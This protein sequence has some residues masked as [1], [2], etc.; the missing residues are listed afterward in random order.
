[1]L[2]SLCH[3]SSIASYCMVYI[4]IDCYFLVVF[5]FYLFCCISFYDLFP[6]NIQ[7]GTAESHE[8]QI[9]VYIELKC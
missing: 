3:M 1:M 9:I 6:F 4:V 5:F 7:G 2:L 8:T